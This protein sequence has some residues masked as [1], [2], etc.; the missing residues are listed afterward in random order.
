MRILSS[1]T[2]GLLLTIFATPAQAQTGACP[3]STAL[4]VNPSGQVCVTV[5]P[6][7]Y[8]GLTKVSG[9]ADV[10][11]VTRLDLLLFDPSKTNTATDAAT[12]TLNIGKPAANAQNAVWVSVPAVL[13]IPIGETW[14]ARVVAVGQPAQTGG[15]V[16]VS[17]RSPESN[18][19]MRAA[20]ATA[21]LA[22][23][24]VSVPA[25]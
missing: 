14:K 3:T 17:A 6:T 5:D 9:G 11:I 20:P 24:G 2:L 8:N 23:L 25:S 22:P 18:P 12:Q 10:P 1:L 15:P 21:P 7:N 4:A 16:Q 13:A 19:F